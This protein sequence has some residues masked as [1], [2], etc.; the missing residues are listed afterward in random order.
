MFALLMI[1]H[2]ARLGRRVVAQWKVDTAAVQCGLAPAQGGVSF[3]GFTVMEL[4]GQLA[5]AVG[6]AR[7]DDNSRGFPVQAMDDTRFRVAV[8]LQAGDQ[9]IAV[10]L[11]A[12]G[13]REQ[14]GG[15]VDHQ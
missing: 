11:G 1:D 5:M 14:Q 2:V 10:V 4:P 13:H 3:F 15:L 6:V 12:A 8:F 9:A 7:Q